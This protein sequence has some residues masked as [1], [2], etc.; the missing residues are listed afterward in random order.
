MKKYFV[1]FVR[2]FLFYSLGFIL[3]FAF[4]YLLRH[5]NQFLAEVFP[6]LFKI[7]N[8]IL[9]R[10]GLENQNKIIALL[11]ALLSV[12][13][14]TYASQRQDNLRYEHIISKTEG[15]YRIREGEKI[16][17]KEFF[18][19]DIFCALTVPLFSLGL[20]LISIP[21][22]APRALLILKKYLEYFIAVPM[23]FTDK[24]GF[25]LGGAFLLFASFILRFLSSYIS[26]FRWRA[27]WL[28]NTE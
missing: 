9:N 18:G 26:L 7:Y 6:A 1:S 23:A 21:L 11:A 10:D 22:D 27:S 24:F 13:V 14:A 25:A 12:F 16:Y 19:A 17:F 2:Y 5:A 28:S 20:T 15:L 4:A 8:P 3:F